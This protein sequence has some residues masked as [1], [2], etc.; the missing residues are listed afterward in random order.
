VRSMGRCAVFSSS[1]VR[2]F[3]NIL[4][5]NLANLALPVEPSPHLAFFL[6]IKRVGGR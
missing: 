2:D 6:L 3:L 5:R 1:R 4:C